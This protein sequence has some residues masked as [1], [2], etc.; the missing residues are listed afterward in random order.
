MPDSWSEINLFKYDPLD[1]FPIMVKRRGYY[2]ACDYKAPDDVS[3][4]N[5][6]HYRQ[7]MRELNH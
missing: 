7:R 2:P 4:E 6:M 3:Y 5:Y 1:Y